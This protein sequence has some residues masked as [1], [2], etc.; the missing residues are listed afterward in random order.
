MAAFTQHGAGRTNVAPATA[1]FRD[2]F[3]RLAVEEAVSRGEVI[4]P[5]EIA[6]R[7]QFLL[8]AHMSRLALAASR[9]RSK[10]APSS[11]ITTVGRADSRPAGPTTSGTDS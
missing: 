6:R 8:R 2:R 9:A 10:A 7:A 11:S 1:A 5:E 3:S 4:G